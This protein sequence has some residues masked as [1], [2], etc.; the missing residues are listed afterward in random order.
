MKE[1]LKGVDSV[2]IT[3]D[4]WTTLAAVSMGGFTAHWIDDS[5]ELHHR[6]LAIR[7][8][9]GMICLGSLLC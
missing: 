6:T 9:A 3:T 4:F 7:E 1:E 5:M 8:M 2:S